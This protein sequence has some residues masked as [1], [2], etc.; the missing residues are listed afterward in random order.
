MFDDFEKYLKVPEQ[1]AAPD[2][3][4]FQAAESVH[5]WMVDKLGRD[6]FVIR[7]GDQTEVFWNDGKRGRADLVGAPPWGR[8]SGARNS[9]ALHMGPIQKQGRG[10]RGI[11]LRPPLTFSLLHAHR[12][13]SASSGRRALSSGRPWATTSPRC[14]GTMQGFGAWGLGG[15]GAWG[16]FGTHVT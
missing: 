1:Y 14:T 2:K 4:A 13:T 5:S 16:S 6:Q 3:A 7:S 9:A 8:M 12:C 15:V 10:L 11:C